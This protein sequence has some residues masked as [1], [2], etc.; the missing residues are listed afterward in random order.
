TIGN[1]LL[2]KG[3]NKKISQTLAKEI[4]DITIKDDQEYAGY[5]INTTEIGSSQNVGSWGVS[6]DELGVDNLAGVKIYASGRSYQ[7]PDFKLVARQSSS[8]RMA[9]ATKVPEPGTIIGLG[10]VAALAFFRRRKS[11]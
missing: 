8:V 11:K 5:Q 4:G 10:S 6:L 2:L 9:K 7:G 3:K 1:Q